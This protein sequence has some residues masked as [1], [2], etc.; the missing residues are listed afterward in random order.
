MKISFR[1]PGVPCEIWSEHLLN[2]RKVQYYYT[3][4]LSN[5]L[6][7]DDKYMLCYCSHSLLSLI[8]LNTHPNSSVN[9]VCSLRLVNRLFCTQVAKCETAIYLVFPLLTGI[10]DLSYGLTDKNL[11]SWGWKIWVAGVMKYKAKSINQWSDD[12]DKFSLHVWNGEVIHHEENAYIVLKGAFSKTSDS[13]SCRIC[14]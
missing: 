6:Y 2:T 1:T 8:Y 9:W 11:G 3:N 7:C 14:I 5:V 13:P 12:Q 10:L 4:L